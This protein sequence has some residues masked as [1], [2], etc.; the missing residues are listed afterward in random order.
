MKKIITILFAGLLTVSLSAQTDQGT[1]L[2]GL[3][4]GLGYS[5]TS[6][7]D[8][9][10]LG[11]ASW[12]DTWDKYSDSHF[13]MDLTDFDNLLESVKFGYFV[14]DNFA[15]GLDLIY[16]STV[17]NRDYV[18]DLNSLLWD[19]V[20]TTVSKFGLE[21]LVRYYFE[22]G[23]GFLFGQLSY[24]MTTNKTKI[25]LSEQDNPDDVIDKV[26]AFTLGV[27][28]SIL[29][30]D[31]ISIEP[32]LFYSMHKE[33]DVDGGTTSTGDVTDR[34]TK[35]NIFGLTFGLTMALY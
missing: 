4:T 11:G 20:K 28:Y 14:V 26:G 9:E 7:T 31:N 34:V 21:P 25:E 33:T 29:V 3:N 24:E 22:M 2:I 35:R 10:G 1:F 18:D 5:M 27:G 32:L 6:V 30:N 16:T 23:S 8:I 13:N 19:D 12:D 15:V 17:T